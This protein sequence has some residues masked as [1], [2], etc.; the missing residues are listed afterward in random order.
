MDWKKSIYEKFTS[1]KKKSNA[2]KNN[3]SIGQ[4]M[5]PQMKE[6]PRNMEKGFLRAQRNVI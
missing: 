5:S 4:E 3:K 1:L 2:T 6:D